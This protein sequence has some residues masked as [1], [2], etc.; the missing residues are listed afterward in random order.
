MIRSFRHCLHLLRVARVLSRHDALF[1]RELLEASPPGFRVVRRL[2]R[3]GLP[4]WAGSGGDSA[5]KTPG[6]RLSAALQSLGPSYIKLG[7]SLATRPD[8]VGG[9][10]ADA[11][12]ELQDHL[13]PFPGETARQIVADELMAPVET[14]FESFDNEPV[15]AASIAQVHFAVTRDG[16]P[17][18]VK[19]L[20]PDVEAAF[21]RDLEPILWI[22]AKLE[23]WQ[24]EMRR[25]RPCEVVRTFAD[26][27]AIEM[28]LRLEAAAA[29]ELG[30]NARANEDGFVIPAVDWRRTGR[31]VLT[32]ER[33]SGLPIADHDA[34]VAAGHDTH[35]LAAKLLRGF[36]SQAM[37][38]G[39]FHADL[40]P[41][42]LFVTEEGEIAA[43]DFGIM[44][45]LDKNSRRYLAEILLG[46]VRADYASVARVHF[47]AGYVPRNK[48]PELF[49]QAMRAVGE[50][51]LGRPAKEISLSRI[52]AQLFQVT[53]AFDMQ[54]QPQ[55]LLLQ[56]TMV[57]AE[58]V[59]QKLD[60]D[61]NTWDITS[62]LVEGLMQAHF[63]PVARAQE[64]LEEGVD[65]VRRL[66]GFLRRAER[67]VQMI[68][69]GSFQLDPDTLQELA[70]ANPH[71]VRLGTVIVWILLAFA[72]G[73][74][75][76][77]G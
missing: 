22:A 59:A 62:P 27:V 37:G 17:V 26:S 20:R 10:V 29:E 12:S 74:A 67:A 11:L 47:D 23:A 45:R 14:L 41:G 30:E 16:K 65:A 9:E 3:L 49:A 25:L 19:I 4:A 58:G 56:K 68:A 5:G 50:P 42:N 72:L 60:P 35:R 40:H 75:F 36:L 61:I 48:S 18:A 54:T 6:E 64:V 31:R 32:T 63:S 51:V 70:K 43:V 69:D 38:D 71:G 8:L 13:P 33:V 15:A 1:P 55:L 76:S 53:K 73:L 2:T 52:L 39:F 44:G 77:L 66:P 7:Q 57:V 28:D 34:L 24:P 21:A 46:F